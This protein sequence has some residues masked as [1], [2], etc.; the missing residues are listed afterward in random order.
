MQLRLLH[1]DGVHFLDF[2]PEVSE[3]AGA[4]TGDPE[5]TMQGK[6]R[7]G[8]SVLS[9]RLNKDT[10]F[11]VTK[12]SIQTNLVSRD[13]AGTTIYARYNVQLESEAQANEVAELF[14]S[15]LPS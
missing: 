4:G 1:S 8:R 7:F 14:R 2:R 12:R 5:E 11:D 10:K 3:S 15:S 6:A 13:A 9:A